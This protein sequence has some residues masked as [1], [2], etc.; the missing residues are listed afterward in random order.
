MNQGLGPLNGNKAPKARANTSCFHREANEL[1]GPQKRERERE[2]KPCLHFTL[3]TFY[4][5]RL[6]ETVDEEGAER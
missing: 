6:K 3:F 5:V 1:S 4:P 2:S